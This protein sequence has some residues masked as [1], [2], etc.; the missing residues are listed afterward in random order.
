MYS[1]ETLS[2]LRRRPLKGECDSPFHCNLSCVLLPHASVVYFIA[3]FYFML[4]FVG[5]FVKLDP[6]HGPAVKGR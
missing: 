5:L 6:L 1:I 3:K 4:Y 2:S